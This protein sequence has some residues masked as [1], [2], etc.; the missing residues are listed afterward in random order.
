[1]RRSGS[2]RAWVLGLVAVS[3]AAACTRQNP[4]FLGPGDGGLPASDSGTG[5][6]GATAGD[7]GPAPDG[8]CDPGSP[9]TAAGNRCQ[10]GTTS[11][12][13]DQPSCESLVPA[14]N[15]TSCALDQVCQDG[16]CIDCAAGARCDPGAVCRAGRLDCS[17]ETGAIACLE[18]G[19]APDGTP[20]A[21]GVCYQGACNS[22]TCGGLAGT[23]CDPGQVCDLNGCGTDVVGVC[24][25]K[26]ATCTGSFAPVC[27]CD[28]TTYG[29]DC[30]RLQAAGA[31]A[32]TH[33][34][35]CL[36]ATEDC[37]NGIDDN[38]DGLVDC[39]DPQ[40]QA[41]YQCVP[42]APDGWAEVGWVDPDGFP[43]CPPELP[44]VL[45]IYDA[46]D[47]VAPPAGCG[48]AC[49]APSGAKCAT[50]MTCY[51]NGFCDG[52]TSITYTVEPTCQAASLPNNSTACE[53]DPPAAAGGSCTAT[54]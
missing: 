54:P 21:A 16:S 12:G 38:G 29:N 18:T 24:V 44:K 43:T 40:C 34:G 53:A 25:S 46:A 11:C 52:M 39:D 51:Y 13:G 2:E 5:A 49:G 3:L 36:N 23:A 33:A 28:G 7:V 26:P 15:G 10:I 1:M 48:C 8:G 32:L 20:C 27:G 50:H 37:M 14:P 47:L 6:D 42:V 35:A 22:A 19:P 30:L 41:A 4:A 31:A 9:C 17:F 45:T